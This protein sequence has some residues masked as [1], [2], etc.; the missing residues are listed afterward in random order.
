MGCNSTR[1]EPALNSTFKTYTARAEEHIT[2]DEELEP[3]LSDYVYKSSKN[4]WRYLKRYICLT[5]EALHVHKSPD[6]EMKHYLKLDY[7]VDIERKSDKQII[8]TSNSKT[9]GLKFSSE[10]SRGRWF[11]QIQKVCKS[12]STEEDE[13]LFDLV[14]ARMKDDSLN[15]DKISQLDSGY[16]KEVGSAVANRTGKPE[17]EPRE[18]KESWE[19]LCVADVD[20]GIG[21]T[22]EEL[23][24]VSK[25]DED[26]IWKMTSTV[27]KRE[28][29]SEDDLLLEDLDVVPDERYKAQSMYLY[30]T[31]VFDD[32]Y[33][34]EQK[35]YEALDQSVRDE[36]SAVRHLIWQLAHTKMALYPKWSVSRNFWSNGTIR[37]TVVKRLAILHYQKSETLSAETFRTLD[38]MASF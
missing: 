32:R 38:T 37:K 24:L 35:K 13:L 18:Y 22:Q 19:H 30:K 14:S 5:E 26:S 3:V 10:E 21:F 20:K 23:L 1:E 8:L 17:R 7:S 33:G 31:N 12:W 2:S 25:K 29:K 16:W 11:S 9:L 6:D 34:L 27:L 36:I 4:G 28:I 15:Y